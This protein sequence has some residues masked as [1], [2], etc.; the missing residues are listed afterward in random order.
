MSTVRVMLDER[1][2]P[3]RIR[4]GSLA[5]LGAAISEDLEVDRVAVV[6]TPRVAAAHFATFE[7]G[8]KDAGVAVTCFEVPDGERAKTLRSAARLYDQCLDAGV[9]RTSVVVGFGG[10]AVCDLTGF[11]AS[12]WLRGVPLVQVPTTLLAQIDASVGG[13]TAVNHPR[14]KNLIGSFYQPRLVWIDPDVLH[15][16]PRREYRCGLAEL[17]KAG[18]LWD[19]DFFSWLELNA[20]GLVALDPDALSHAI[21]RAV[22]IEAEIVSLV[23]RETGLRALLNLGH[24]L[25]HAIESVAG[26]RRV[27]HG[28]AVAMGMVFAC[29]LS[30]LRCGLAPEATGRVR[31]LL[32]RVGLR[33]TA[34]DWEAQ[35]EA[36]LR[37]IAV[38]KKVSGGQVGFVALKEL[39]RAEI[40]RLTPQEILETVT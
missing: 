21:R 25:G 40:V 26:Y 13:K 34:P 11:V 20:G 3:I 33:T 39:G 22:E 18:V 16:L 35:R 31:S 36:Y 38:D 2:Y 28:E 37:A 19:A 6:T 12:T 8:M 24:T 32:E 4:P 23:E 17:I 9:D 15:T 29:E 7:R 30:E 1:S 10:G 5:Q 14:G 27:R